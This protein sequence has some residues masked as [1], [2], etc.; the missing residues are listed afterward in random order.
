MEYSF[1]GDY[2]RI[3]YAYGSAI[4]IA[5]FAIR[6]CR[7]CAFSYGKTMYAYGTAISIAGFAIS[8][9]STI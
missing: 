4:S 2:G 6:I 3:A 7:F 9:E 5:G 8:G 1:G